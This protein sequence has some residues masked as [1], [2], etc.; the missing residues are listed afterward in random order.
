MDLKF[1]E[2]KTWKRIGD[3]LQ[4]VELWKLL[5][6][7]SSAAVA[8]RFAKSVQA[9][10][11][12]TI[13]G[14]LAAFAAGALLAAWL[15]SLFRKLRY[16]VRRSRTTIELF[17]GMNWT[18]TIKHVGLPVKVRARVQI[19]EVGDELDQHFEPYDVHLQM[20]AHGPSLQSVELSDETDLAKATIATLQTLDK[21][22][23]Q[24]DICLPGLG[25][26]SCVVQQQ[27]RLFLVM[28]VTL[29]VSSPLGV[30]KTYELHKAIAQLDG[31]H[32]Q[33]RT[34]EQKKLDSRAER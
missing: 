28:G 24:L 2:S 14:T 29:L 23:K 18:L 33:E 17:G 10:T 12:I 34:E 8:A 13:F 11:L 3:V 6:G 20:K 9:G 19:M 16:L 22:A 4:A 25:N 1:T 27:E 5:V 30:R 32:V 7:F 15:A 31:F 21:T 26:K